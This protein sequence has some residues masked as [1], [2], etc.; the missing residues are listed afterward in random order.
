MREP[1]SS[2][3]VSQAQPPSCLCLRPSPI[4]HPPQKRS[5]WLPGQVLTLKSMWLTS[6][7]GGNPA[8]TEAAAQG[9]LGLGSLSTWE[10]L[11]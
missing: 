10:D 7:N 5:L 3:S 6:D 11:E 1:S 2:P 8:A 4:C 9:G